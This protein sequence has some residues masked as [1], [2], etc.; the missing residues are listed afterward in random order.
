EVGEGLG[1]ETVGPEGAG[2]PGA[3]HRPRSVG[4]AAV[5]EGEEGEEPGSLPGT[6][7]TQGLPADAGV[8]GTEEA[9]GQ[10]WRSVLRGGPSREGLF[11]GRAAGVPSL[12]TRFP[13]VDNTAGTAGR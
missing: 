6:Q 5:A 3:V 9:E 8:E 1:L 10:R 4:L 12:D 13:S 11:P 2:Q 7:A